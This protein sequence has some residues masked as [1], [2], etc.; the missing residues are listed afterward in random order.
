MY[1]AQERMVRRRLRRL[2]RRVE[3]DDRAAI[4]RALSDDEVLGMLTCDC[5]AAAGISEAESEGYGNALTDFFEW[6]LA[7]QDEIIAFI[8]TIIG[9]FT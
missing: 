1:T 4:D 8:K 9:L 7:N 6:L 2:R 3:G 5:C